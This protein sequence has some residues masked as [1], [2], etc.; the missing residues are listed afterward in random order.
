MQHFQLL[1][2]GG[3]VKIFSQMMTESAIF[4]IFGEM[5]PGW[6]PGPAI[7]LHLTP[8]KTAGSSNL[9]SDTEL[10][11][12]FSILSSFIKL[13]QERE[14]KKLYKVK[15]RLEQAPKSLFQPVLW[16]SGNS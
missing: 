9:A 1:G 4:A 6:R 13:I 8:A 10:V 14:E 12:A 11:T 7:C 15:S 3:A 5:L 2:R 16:L